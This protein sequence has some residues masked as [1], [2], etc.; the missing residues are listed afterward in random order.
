M[1]LTLKCAPWDNIQSYKNENKRLFKLKLTCNLKLI[2]KEKAIRNTKCLLKLSENELPDIFT[3]IK[4]SDLKCIL[5]SKNFLCYKLVVSLKQSY[6]DNSNEK[7]YGK[8]V[9]KTI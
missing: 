6:V 9:C 5:K 2:N 7:I 1:N 3:L 4:L 8:I